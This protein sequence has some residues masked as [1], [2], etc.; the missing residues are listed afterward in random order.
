[1]TKTKKTTVKAAK[2]RAM[3]RFR[4]GSTKYL[5]LWVRSGWARVLDE[6]WGACASMT[7]GRL[8]KMRRLGQCVSPRFHWVHKRCACCK[9]NVYVTAAR[10][11]LMARAEARK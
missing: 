4:V 5:V 9:Q 8:A 6:K 2:V 7:V 3:D 11:L 1:M 10:A